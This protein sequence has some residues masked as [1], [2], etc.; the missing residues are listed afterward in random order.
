MVLLSPSILSAD[1]S[2][3]GDSCRKVLDAGADMIHFDVMDGHFVGN[4]SFGLPVLSS[5]HK[6]LPEAVFDV[7]LMITHPLRY[8][9]DFVG[10]GANIITFH[11][12]ASDSI[13]ATIHAIKAFGCKAGIAVNPTTPVEAVFPYLHKLDLVLIMGVEPGQGGQAFL[14]ETLDKIRALRKECDRQCLNTLKISVDGG[15][16]AET[17]APECIRA[18]ADILVSGSAVFNAPDMAAAIRSFKEI[19]I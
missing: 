17:T 2:T 8:V 19:Q 6:T 10:V 15:V 16:K 11:A 18:G 1:F 4:L 12:E 5:L 14:P 3:L 13:T 7:H 9:R